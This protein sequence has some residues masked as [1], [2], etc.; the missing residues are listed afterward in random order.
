MTDEQIVDL[1]WARSEQAI[2]ET[3]KAYGSYF[4]YIARGI[5]RNEE[6]AEEIVNDTYM[7]AWYIMPPQRP[8]PLKT[9]LGRITRQ[10]S[11]NRLEKN[12]ASKRGGGQYEAVLEE[13]SECTADERAAN[14]EELMI[15]RDMLNRFLWEL[16]EESRR[17]F[18]GR[19]WYMRPIAEIA[20]ACG[21]GESKVKMQLKRSREKLREYLRKEGFAV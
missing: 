9:F 7:K 10:L 13:L 17:I 3:Q 11:I 12:T 21:C 2:W 16:P 14:P 20:K 4:C 6:D 1:Y 5:L 18:V 19:Y 8:N 15:L